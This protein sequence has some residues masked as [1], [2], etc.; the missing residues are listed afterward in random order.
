MNQL[1]TVGEIAEG[2]IQFSGSGPELQSGP[3]ISFGDREPS[4]PS[5]QLHKTR[6]A[7]PPVFG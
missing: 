4:R 7:S 1:P 3:R 6:A 5:D 2:R